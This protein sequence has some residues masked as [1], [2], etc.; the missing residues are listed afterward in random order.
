LFV[1]AGISGANRN[2]KA[3]EKMWRVALFSVV[4]CSGATVREPLDLRIDQEQDR[5]C[6][7]QETENPEA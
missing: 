4:V 1:C 3:T 7:G 5:S 6:G 2:I